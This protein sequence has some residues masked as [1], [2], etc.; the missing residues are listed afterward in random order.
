LA[1]FSGGSDGGGGG[2]TPETGGPDPEPEPQNPQE[3]HPQPQRN[4]SCFDFVDQLVQRAFDVPWYMSRGDVGNIMMY[5]AK[6]NPFEKF[7][8]NGMNDPNGFNPTL[9]QFGQAGDVYRHVL[10]FAGGTLNRVQPILW[11]AE[12]KDRN[13]VAAGRQESITELADDQAG[14]HVGALMDQAFERRF[15]R[16]GLRN[17]L[18]QELCQ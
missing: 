14:R 17:I 16:N 12:R 5:R 8:P 10:F 4:P 6:Q 7:M 3:P 2:T 13:Q 15:D 18:R 11:A 9:T 1:G